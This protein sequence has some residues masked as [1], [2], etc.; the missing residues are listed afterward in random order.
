MHEIPFQAGALMA[1]MFPTK[2][3]PDIIIQPS[4]QNISELHKHAGQHMAHE[5]GV[6]EELKT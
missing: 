3:C 4:F 1:F 6:L 5:E 2:T